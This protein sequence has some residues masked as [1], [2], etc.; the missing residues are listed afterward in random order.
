MANPEHL[1]ILK[2]GVG[3][4]NQWRKEQP[5]VRPNLIK[6]SLMGT[7]LREANLRGAEFSGGRP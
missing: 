2:Q 1:G 4:R 3:S 6:A 7:N 5:D